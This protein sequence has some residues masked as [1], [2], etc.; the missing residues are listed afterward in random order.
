MSPSYVCAEV[1][2]PTEAPL[3][4]LGPTPEANCHQLLSAVA[5]CIF[6]PEQLLWHWSPS[7]S[8][9]WEVMDKTPASA[10]RQ[11]L[12]SLS[13]AS[14]GTEPSCLPTVTRSFTHP[15]R[16]GFLPLPLSLP[17]PSPCL[18]DHL[19]NERLFLNPCLRVC[20]GGNP[21]PDVGITQTL[22][23]WYYVLL[24]VSRY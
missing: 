15:A 10:P 2:G 1:K 6:L 4:C 11:V 17:Y 9:I 14:R 8:E 16:T 7:T 3:T 12:H 19:S 21:S 20:L 22:H 18:L 5:S 13:E 23:K 24:V